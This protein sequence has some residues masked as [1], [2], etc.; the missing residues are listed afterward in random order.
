MKKQ[1]SHLNL[2]PT[3]SGT[4]SLGMGPQ[5]PSNPFGFSSPNPPASDL[6]FFDTPP[7]HQNGQN[8][9]QQQQQ[10]DSTN[11]FAIVAELNNRSQS[12][13]QRRKSTS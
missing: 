10:M 12:G 13:S 5:P 8:G 6:L 3:S 4:F 2:A 11:P 9:Q 1:T 7:Q